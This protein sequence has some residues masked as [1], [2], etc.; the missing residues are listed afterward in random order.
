MHCHPQWIY[1]V[2]SYRFNQT[3]T[4]RHG[5]AHC[6]AIW[7]ERNWN[8]GVDQILRF[9]SIGTPCLAK[10]ES[11]ITASQIE[12]RVTAS[13]AAQSQSQEELM[14]RVTLMNRLVPCACIS[15]LYFPWALHAQTTKLSTEYL[16]T[17]YAPLEAGQA[18]D[19]TLYI[20][21]VRPRG[22]V[23]GPK[24]NGTLVA[25]SGDW[26]RVLPSGVSRLDVRATIKTD[27]GALI[28]LTYNGIFKDTKES[29][30]RANK[31]EILRSQDLYFMIAPTMQTSAK[32]YEWLNG[33]Q[34][35]GKMVSYKSD[36]FVKYDIF[37]VR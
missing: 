14:N 7:T 15:L 27:D 19:A 11:A 2:I 8:S 13:G 1:P 36:T 33:V 32:R 24:I 20:Y 26:F 37:V 25:P 9:L 3:A 22:W 6:P 5:G 31:G 10:I 4:K 18:V 35:I 34:C 17:L 16:M 28:Y 12:T 23:K 21:N 30:D 29:E